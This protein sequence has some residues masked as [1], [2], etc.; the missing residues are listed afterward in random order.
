MKTLNT[1]G[2]I[3]GLIGVLLIFVWGP[4]QPNLEEGIGLG[5]EDGTPIDSTG[6][7]VK[8]YNDEVLQ[9]K[10]KHNIMSRLG[11]GLIFIGFLFQIWA[12]WA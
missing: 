3:L 9:K 6:K 12:T 11:L 7:T 8:E 1:I 10:I 2:L 5:L 4:P